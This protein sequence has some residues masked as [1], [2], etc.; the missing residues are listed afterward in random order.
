MAEYALEGLPLDKLTEATTP[1]FDLFT[2]QA[3]VI[4]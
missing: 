3:I 2:K 4:L 1:S